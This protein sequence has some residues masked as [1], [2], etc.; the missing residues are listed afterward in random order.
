MNIRLIYG[1]SAYSY[2][3]DPNFSE[4]SKSEKYWQKVIDEFYKKYEGV[5]RWHERL[6]QEATTTGKVV[7]PTGR[8]FKYE[9][10]SKRGDLV[11]P[12][13]KILNYPVQALGADLMCIARVSFARRFKQQQVKG[14]LISTVHDSIVADV[15]N[16]EV[17]KT[18]RM[19][20]EV[21]RDLPANFEKL[22]KKKYTLPLRCEVQYGPN[23][24]D[25]TDFEYAV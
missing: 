20:Y 3:N 6:M 11:W 9:P 17:E 1:G 14:V 7:I 18:C 5:A 8:M 10:E 21:F 2:A 15:E 12:R 24:K 4:V 13:T 16:D 25:L 22:F 19:F 23:L